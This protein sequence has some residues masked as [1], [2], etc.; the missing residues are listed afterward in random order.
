MG[1]LVSENLSSFQRGKESIKTLGLGK[2]K[3]KRVINDYLDSVKPDVSSPSNVT[4][5]NRDISRTVTK[6]F[7]EL[8]WEVYL[9]TGKSDWP[10][11]DDYTNMEEFLNV[12]AGIHHRVYREAILDVAEK[13]EYED[14]EE[15][16][17]KLELI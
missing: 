2:E 4:Q 3:L 9:K 15:I 10:R 14:I 8:S 12:H 17:K 7:E 13:L 16:L 1:K 6:L 11:I 5:Y